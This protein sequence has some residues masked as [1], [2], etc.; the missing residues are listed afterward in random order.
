MAPFVVEVIRS[1]VRRARCPAWLVTDGGWACVPAGRDAFPPA[2]GRCCRRT[3]VC[4]PSRIAEPFGHRQREGTEPGAGGSFIWPRPSP[5]VDDGAIGLADLH[6]CIPGRG[7][8]RAFVRRRRRRPKTA[9]GVAMRAIGSRNDR[10]AARPRRTVP[11]S[12]ADERGQQ[13]DDLIP[14][15]NFDFRAEFVEGRRTTNRPAFVAVDFAAAVDRLAE[16]VEDPPQRPLRPGP[17]PGRGVDRFHPRTRPSVEP[18]RRKP[19]RP[20][21]MLLSFARQLQRDAL[22]RRVD[23]EGVIDLGKVIFGKYGIEGRTDDLRDMPIEPPSS[24]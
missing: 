1:C 18:R 24:G 5:S 20:P 21:Q 23:L 22:V 13:V 10:L 19:H 6:S 9:V 14:V 11:P 7:R 15:A 8:F 3:T 2:A 16:Q 17:K 12:A 4:R